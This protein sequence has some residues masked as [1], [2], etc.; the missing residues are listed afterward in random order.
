M[1]AIRN[2]AIRAGYEAP[3]PFAQ[4]DEQICSGCAVCTRACP[5]GAIDRVTKD[6][7]RGRARRG[8]GG[9]TPSACI[10]AF[11]WRPALAAP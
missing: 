6:H 5:Y 2:V 8:S 10:V 3:G 1:K 11:A 4:V 7:C 9:A